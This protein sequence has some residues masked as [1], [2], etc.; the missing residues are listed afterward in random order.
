MARFDFSPYAV[1][2]NAAA[3]T[4]VDA[5]ETPAGRRAAWAVNVTG[6]TALVRAVAGHGATLVHLSSDYVF[7][8][9]VAEHDEDEPFSPLG[10][11]G[12]T[13][14]AGDAVVATLAR[15]YVLRTSWVVGPGQRSFIA[16][17][18]DL[19]DRGARPRVVADQHGR[20]TFTAEIARAVDHLLRVGA[21]YGT[22]NLSNAG[23]PT[24]WAD[25]ARAVFVARGR[26]AEDVL[27]VTTA[28]Y[29]ADRLLAPRPRQSTL[30]LDKIRAT[31]FTPTPAVDRLRAH[32]ATLP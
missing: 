26:P 22:Y 1:V 13:K 10:V 12:Q 24:T 17:M 28:E 30:A 19:A 14:A 21:P 11:Y 7:D 3:Y 29:G 6:V 27:A 15:H 16:R 8:G 31:G 23:E 9:T 20:L 2:V 4:A 5:A 18:A 25:V 32:L